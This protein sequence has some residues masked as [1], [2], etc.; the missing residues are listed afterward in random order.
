MKIYTDGACSDNL[1]PAA[2]AWLVLDGERV[3]LEDGEYLG[4]STNNEAEYSAIIRGLEAC[5]AEGYRDV[6][7]HSDSQLCVRQINGEWRVRE[8]RLKPL[9]EDVQRL[10]KEFERIEFEWVGR[11]DEWI[12]RCDGRARL[13]CLRL[14][15]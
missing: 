10:M 5:I 9:H 11:D 3:L 7:A 14:N 6:R 15:Y 8:P 2:A 4:H 12:A 1:G 13:G